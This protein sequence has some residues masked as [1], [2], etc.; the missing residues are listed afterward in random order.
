VADLRRQ[1]EKWRTLES[2]EGAE[3]DTLRR[4]RIELE[5]RVKELEA[6]AE[7]AETKAQKLESAAEKAKAKKEKYK[8]ALDEYRR[9]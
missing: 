4:S 7:E 9:Y 5:V 2:R 8:D 6:R 3:M 1:L